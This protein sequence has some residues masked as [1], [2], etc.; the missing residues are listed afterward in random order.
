MRAK[1]V[2]Q[3]S[4]FPVRRTGSYRHK[5]STGMCK[6]LLY[7]SKISDI[8]DILENIMIFSNPAYLL[9]LGHGEQDP[10]HAE[11]DLLRQDEGHRQRFEVNDTCSRAE[12]AT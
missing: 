7:I 8:F 10:Q 12:S 6:C 9:V 11:R 2:N 4:D 5:K 3:S 1:I